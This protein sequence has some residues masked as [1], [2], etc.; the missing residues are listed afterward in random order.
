MR[1]QYDSATPQINAVSGGKATV[2]IQDRRAYVLNGDKQENF[3][4]LSRGGYGNP[5]DVRTESNQPLADDFG[6]TIQRALAAK[7][8]TEPKLSESEA[9]KRLVSGEGKGILVLLQEWKSD[10]YMGTKLFYDVTVKVFD[11]SGN[12]LGQNRING[13][14]DLGSSV[15]NP[16]AH[17]R[18]AV[19]EAFRRKI[20]QL[21]SDPAIAKNL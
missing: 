21:F 4:G 20:E 14:E 15:W 19:P 6:R 5:F 3:V 12:L 17:A 2:A 9:V 16:P 8:V 18:E 10:T 1:H 13:S 11:G 7:G